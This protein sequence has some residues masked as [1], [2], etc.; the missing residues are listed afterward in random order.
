M[1]L[2]DRLNPKKNPFFEHGEGASS[3]RTGTASASG[4]VTAQ[5]DREHLDRYKDATGFF[6]F[7]DTIDDEEVA[8]AL[9]ARAESWLRGKGMK[10]ARGPLSLN[11]NEEIGLPRRRLRHAAVHHDAAPPAVPGRASSRRPATRRR[12]TSSRGRYE[13]GELNARVKR[14]AR[15]DQGAPGDHV[16]HAS[17]MK[18]LD[19][20]RRALRRHLQRRVERQLGLRPV[21]AQRGAEDGGRL[22]AAPHARDHAASCRST[23]SRRRSRSRSRTST[24]SSRDLGRQALPAR[25][26]EAPLAP[27]GA[28]AEER[29]A[30][31]SSA[32]AR[33]G[34]TSA[35]TPACSAPSCTPR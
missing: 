13:V 31:S 34:G 15:R 14:G 22:Q 28:R 4:A 5:I 19:T 10:R 23:A 9:L 6:G 16:P 29:R 33:S 3:A 30:S 20:R 35:S 8:R 26:P 7:L 2:K 21:H 18:N 32:S 25:A 27:Q 1:E 11:I 12:R 24:S 17:R